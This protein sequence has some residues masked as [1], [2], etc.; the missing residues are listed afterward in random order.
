MKAS[1][2][3]GESIHAKNTRDMMPEKW[4]NATTEEIKKDKIYKTF[5]TFCHATNYDVT[6]KSLAINPL[7]KMPIT[8]VDELQK[9]WFSIHPGI[10]EWHR[11]TARFLDGS[12]CWRCKTMTTTSTCPNCGT[13]TGHVAVN[14]FGYRIYFF[15]PLDRLLA[16][17]LAWVP[18]ST[19]AIVTQRGLIT[20]RRNFTSLVQALLHFHHILVFQIKEKDLKYIDEI[21]EALNSIEVPYADPLRIPWGFASSADNWGN[22]G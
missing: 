2:R 16:T 3:A 6:P 17:A 7:I 12:Q 10:K 15:E 19:F 1:F 9:H 11:R 18:Q 13:T 5:K 22:C 21:K 8:K 4:G 14:A 20:L